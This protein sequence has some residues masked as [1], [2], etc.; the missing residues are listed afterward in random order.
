VATALVVLAA[1]PGA[2][3][4]AVLLTTDPA[5]GAVLKRSPAQVLLRFSESVETELGS[6]RVYD[7]GGDRVDSGQLSRPSASSVA[8]PIGRG[9]PRGTY[10][11]AWRVISADTH[12]VHGAF[13]FSVGTGTENADAIAARVLEGEATPR[14][15]DAGFTVVRFLSFALL[16]AVVGGTVALAVV[17]RRVDERLRARLSRLLA[18][19]A[20]VL[21]PV[22]LAGIVFE[23]AV[24]SGFGLLDAARWSVISAVGRTRF[25]EAWL[26][27]A[28]LAALLGLAVALVRRPAVA[29]PLSL[30]LAAG[31]AVTTTA[32][33]HASIGGAFVFVV[34]LL[35][36]LAA[37]VWFGG[38]LFTGLALRG[39]GREERWPL[40][41]TVVPR[42]S[43]IA[44]GSV[45]LLLVAGV[46]NGYL[47][48]RAWR[49]LWDTTYGRLLLAKVGLVLPLLV[50]GAYNNRRSV[51]RLRAQ[52]ASALERTRFL[53]AIGTELVLVVAVVALTAVLV[54]EVPAKALVASGGPFAAT[55]GIGPYE[56]NVI[57]DPA[58]AGPNAL[59][60]YL[61]SRSGQPAQVA[62]AKVSASL[63]GQGIGPL[64]LAAQ[65]AGPGHYI[66]SGAPL[67]IPGQWRLGFTV[68]R[69]EFD[70][71]IKTI[72]VPIRK[73]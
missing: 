20:F 40:A 38:L 45:G 19:L 60:L 26:A 55:T 42:L 46:V 4:H 72:D 50:L 5:D 70:E 12:P 57:V 31:L 36:V 24:A 67:A 8:V 35:H 13:V 33:G 52:V 48:V 17:L 1:A 73:D 59:H 49:G 16:L 68:R 51:P 62:E 3:A 6:V 65:P 71:W 66:V 27:R 7:G 41:A 10:T 53:R 43:L 32:A 54:S 29:G 11:V 18:L 69:G 61:L 14:S 56:L 25:G 21:V 28:A 9:L 30:L 23:G 34:D 44:L 2:F 37:S 47:E 15:L 39:A 22:S 64:R 63:P 58:R